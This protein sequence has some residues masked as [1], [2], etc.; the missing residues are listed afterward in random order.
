MC[1]E[2]WRHLKLRDKTIYLWLAVAVSSFFVFQANFSLLFVFRAPAT[3]LV[4][5]KCFTELAHARA[6]SVLPIGPIS[7][8]PIFTNKQSHQNT[9]LFSLAQ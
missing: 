4:N 7:S 5:T 9:L 1:K 3:L 2:H 8:L 6:F